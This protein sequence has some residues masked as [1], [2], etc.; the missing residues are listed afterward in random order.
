MAR[1]LVKPKYA[2]GEFGCP[3]RIPPDATSKVEVGIN[4]E[5]SSLSFS[6][7]M[8][9]IEVVS[10]IDVKVADNFGHYTEEEKA[11]VG[12]DELLSVTNAHREVKILVC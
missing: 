7:V 4:A 11:A 6:V 9:E 12:L 2:F 5:T 3:P 10:Y 1:F 8:F